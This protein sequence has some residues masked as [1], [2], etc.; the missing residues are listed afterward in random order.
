[1]GGLVCTAYSCRSPRFHACWRPSLPHSC[2]L[3][4]SYRSPHL[5]G[6]ISVEWPPIISAAPTAPASAACCWL[7]IYEI[8][9]FSRFRRDPPRLD[10]NGRSRI[11]RRSLDQFVGIDHIDEYVA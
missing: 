4:S 2:S 6:L 5:A 7:P 10:R 1:M 8:G 3:A 11:L 9:A